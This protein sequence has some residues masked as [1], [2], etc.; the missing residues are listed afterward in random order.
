MSA[1]GRL[2]ISCGSVVCPSSNSRQKS[3][4][5]PKSKWTLISPGIFTST[6]TTKKR[7]RRRRI[8][9][10][11]DTQIAFVIHTGTALLIRAGNSS[12]NCRLNSNGNLFQNSGKHEELMKVGVS[13]FA[14]EGVAIV[15][16]FC[17]RKDYIY[18][19]NSGLQASFILKL[20]PI[21]V[22]I[23]LPMM[24]PA[25]KSENQWMVTETPRPM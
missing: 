23:M 3:F 9:F 19:L 5:F 2:I 6:L 12:A 14:S 17:F 10:R 1:D 22:P 11:T 8:F 15:N 20:L 13:S 25:T 18:Y 4:V 7:V 21:T 16:G 24:A